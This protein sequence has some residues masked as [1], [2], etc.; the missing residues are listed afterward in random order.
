MT[1]KKFI[2]K[3]KKIHGDIYDYS[4]VNY[5]NCNTKVKIICPKHGIFMQT[6][7]H[8]LSGEGCPNCKAS[9]G[10][11]KIYKLLTDNKLKFKTEKCIYYKCKK[12]RVDFVV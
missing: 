11:R 7:L 9:S 1:T 10:E 12:M 2:E 5:V 6:P 3:A 8:H 4:L